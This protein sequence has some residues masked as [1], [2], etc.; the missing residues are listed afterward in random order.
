MNRWKTGAIFLALLMTF[1]PLASCRPADPGGDPGTADSTGMGEVP[2]DEGMSI[3]GNTI[4][5]YQILCDSTVRAQGMRY[6]NAI[7][8]FCHVSLPVSDV[9]TD[10]K[11]NIRLLLDSAVPFDQCSIR[12]VENELQ[13]RAATA[14]ILG[15]GVQGF[16]KLLKD[17]NGIFPAGYETGLMMEAIPI[18]KLGGAEATIIGETDKD[19]VSYRVGEMATFHCALYSGSQLVGVPYFYY[20]LYDESTGQLTSDFVDGSKGSFSVSAK[21]GSA[22]F[23]YLSVW[24]YDENY[25]KLDA[26]SGLT[27]IVDGD[28]NYCGAA[29]FNI[30][31]LHTAGTVP[32]DFDAYWRAQVDALYSTPLEIVAM[33]DL[34]VEGNPYY[35]YYVALRCAVDA[36]STLATG[37]L[38][39]PRDANQI[40]LKMYFNGYGVNLPMPIYE[41]NTA[42]L[43]MCAH[44]IE[45]DRADPKSAA[46]DASYW[47]SVQSVFGSAG[48]EASG[49]ADR[50]TVYF[51]G[52]ILRNLQGARFL[53]SFFGE[54]GKKLWD[55]KT[56]VCQGGSMGAFQ[57][58][59]VAALDPNVSGA[60][61]SVPWLCDLKGD[62]NGNLRKKSTF[63]MS[64]SEA[65]MYYDTTAFAHLIRCDV[66]IECGLGDQL[67]PASGI[68][69]L[70]NQLTCNKKITFIQ[71]RSHSWVPAGSGRFVLQAGAKT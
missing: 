26:S 57:S 39:Y 7:Y 20:E 46:Y 25:R 13:I 64:F 71:N 56:F 68:T 10:G 43:F 3:N 38:T 4:S 42:V 59:T 45:L 35:T 61:V 63:R 60:V 2:V 41:E 14:D 49:N 17:V 52:M 50:D 40:G 51:R 29:G 58:L 16:S 34:S 9:D 28:I 30:E 11:W 44:S 67:C 31:E 23:V 66:E 48:F 27:N 32:S 22:G 53:T 62:S 5:R 36:V 54:D 19:A 55:G 6:K 18:G 47:K 21:P 8:S 37:Y 69:V 65:L 33:T 15:L 24:V 70:Y 12:V 1:M